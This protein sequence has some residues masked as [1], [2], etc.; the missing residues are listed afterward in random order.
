LDVNE[1]FNK[2][3]VIS[4]ATEN[5]RAYLKSLPYSSDPKADNDVRYVRIGEAIL[6]TP[7]VNDFSNLLVNGGNAIIPIGPQEVPILGT[8]NF[9]T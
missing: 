4:A 3:S 5:I 8:V 9:S 6:D 2:N 7:G 1:G